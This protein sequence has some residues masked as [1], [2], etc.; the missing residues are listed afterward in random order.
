MTSVNQ[1]NE[2]PT[3]NQDEII[4]SL[5]FLENKLF[6]TKDY[7]TMTNDYKNAKFGIEYLIR[8]AKNLTSEIEEWCN[9]CPNKSIYIRI[10]FFHPNTKKTFIEAIMNAQLIKSESDEC[11]I[12]KKYYFRKCLEYES[13]IFD[14]DFVLS[15]ELDNHEFKFTIESI[16]EDNTNIETVSQKLFWNVIKY[17]IYHESVEDYKLFIENA[18]N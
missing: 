3:M 18:I 10:F 9:E 1:T 8:L 15:D 6:F 16:N 17:L 12:E 11:K 2:S 4:E 14:D 5:D 7:V 13:T